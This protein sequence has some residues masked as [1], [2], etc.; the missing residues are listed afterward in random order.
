MK[1]ESLIPA[2]WFYTGESEKIKLNWFLFELACKL[3]EH[4]ESSQNKAIRKWLA[5]RSEEQTAEFCAYFS[6]RVRQSVLAFLEGPE[7]AIKMPEYFVSDYCHANT[8]R[9]YKAILDI[10][11][12]AWTGLL[13]SCN[14]CTCNCIDERYMRCEFFDRME[15]GGYLS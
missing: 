9:E 8:R 13:Q 10:A 7:E 5:Q 2:F 1:V 6:K 3:Y 14:A 12:A 15:R 4:I 11:S